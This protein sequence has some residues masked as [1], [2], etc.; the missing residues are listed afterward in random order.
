VVEGLQTAAWRWRWLAL[1]VAATLLLRSLVPA[2][3]PLGDAQALLQEPDAWVHAGG[4]QQRVTGEA[5][6]FEVA[7][8]ATGPAIATRRIEAPAPAA[9]LQLSACVAAPVPAQGVNLFLASLRGG[10]LDF[11]R[12]YALYDLPGIASDCATDLLPRRADDG[13]AYVQ[14]QLAGRESALALA[15]L[16]LTPLAENPSWRQLRLPALALGVLLLL[17]LFAPYGLGHRNLLAWGG[18]GTVVAIII[19]CCMSVSLKADVFAL[20]TGGRSLP[21]PVDPALRMVQPFPVGGFSL[22]TLGHALLFAL[23]TLLLAG[24][25]AW[26]WLDLVGLGATTEILQIYVPG[27]GPGLS[28]AL[29]DWQGVAVAMLLLF[30]VRRIQRVSLLL[31]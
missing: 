21:V 7:P 5:V 17:G 13:P 16:A 18:L 20:L 25:R 19:G 10:A 4:M 15:S 31:H 1:Y 27:R 9:F 29:V 14:L 11:N 30:V 12:Q 2:T 26:G 22:F 3:Q 24:R 23:A 8:G 6:R 28:D